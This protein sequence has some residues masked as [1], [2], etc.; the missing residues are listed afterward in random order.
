M[1]YLFLDISLCSIRLVQYTQ[2]GSFKKGVHWKQ[3][4]YEKKNVEALANAMA[5]ACEYLRCV[6]PRHALLCPTEC[7]VSVTIRVPFLFSLQY[8]PIIFSF[9]FLCRFPFLHSLLLG[10][11]LQT[12]TVG[13]AVSFCS[14]IPR[15]CCALTPLQ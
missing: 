3:L 13:P 2:L 6:R 9:A 10:V 15:E 7:C 5:F 4:F 1:S 8:G 14:E 11:R 12:P